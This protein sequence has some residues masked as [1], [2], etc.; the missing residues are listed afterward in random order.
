MCKKWKTEMKP[1]EHSTNTDIKKLQ[2]C[3]KMYK[4]YRNTQN[5]QSVQKYIYIYIY[6]YTLYYT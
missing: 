2:K 1:I 4:N 3:Y 6:I 5:I